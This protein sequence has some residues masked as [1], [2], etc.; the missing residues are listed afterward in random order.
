MRVDLG[1]RSTGGK[2]KA[3]AK[4]QMISRRLYITLLKTVV[5]KLAELDV[6]TGTQLQ[7]GQQGLNCGFLFF[8]NLLQWA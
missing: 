4:N 7:E 1:G 5:L 2:K 3:K 6:K 8:V